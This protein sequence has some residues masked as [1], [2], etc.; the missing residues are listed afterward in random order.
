[1]GGGVDAARADSTT[2]CTRRTGRIIAGQWP[3]FVRRS[4]G[5]PFDAPRPVAPE[6]VEQEG[7][8]ILAS[9]EEELRLILAHSRQLQNAL[10]PWLEAHGLRKTGE[11][12]ER[13][14]LVVEFE[15]PTQ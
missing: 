8:R 9:N 11:H 4:P 7:G 10:P 1:M 5:T 13:T 14:L 3:V 15:K 2:M 6:W 12:R